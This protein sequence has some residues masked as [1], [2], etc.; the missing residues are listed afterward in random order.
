[1][2]LPDYKLVG[3]PGKFRNG[4]RKKAKCFAQRYRLLA[5]L[6]RKVRSVSL[7]TTDLTTARR[8]VVRYVEDA[9]RKHLVASNP[10][11][12]TAS[13][14]IGAVLKEYTDDLAARGNSEKQIATVKT[15][16]RKVVEQGKLKEYAQVD[17]VVVTKAIN[18]LMKQHGFGV[19]T[20]NRYR[21]AMRAWTRWMKKN[22]RWP[23]NVLE[24]MPKFKGDDT[25]TR[26]RAILTD[27]EFETLLS[28]TKDGPD[29][30]RLSGEQRYWLY[31]IASQTGLR[32]Q[33]LNSLKP[34]SF[35]LDAEPPAV[36]V[37]CTISKRR[38]TDRILL[39]RDFA[40]LLRMWLD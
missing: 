37:H 30:R 3:L 31:L 25:P 17:A 26:K 6:P 34:T 4:H 7:K 24:D 16:I 2:L 8:R 14:G 27:E 19:V 12:R 20:A 9:I 13:R 1:M 23:G 36:T 22:G 40:E 32:A 28:V 29:R 5:E 10:E 15:R 38:K 18:Q 39:R 11:A 21:E 33:E 35:D